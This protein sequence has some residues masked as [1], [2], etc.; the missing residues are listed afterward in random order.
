MIHHMC[1]TW[2]QHT[3][4]LCSRPGLGAPKSGCDRAIR[5]QTSQLRSALSQL[6]EASDSDASTKSDAKK[7]I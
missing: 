7:I 6:R 2:S 1:E 4:C 3:L 5:Y